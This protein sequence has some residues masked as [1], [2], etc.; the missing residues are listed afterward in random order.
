MKSVLVSGSGVER[1]CSEES[2]S[3]YPAQTAQSC[4]L[5]V[6]RSRHQVEVVQCATITLLGTTMHIAFGHR[7]SN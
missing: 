6:Q 7:L 5:L 1:E 4:S 2:G 3:V